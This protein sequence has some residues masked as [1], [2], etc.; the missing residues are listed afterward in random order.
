MWT[1]AEIDRYIRNNL[2]EGRYL[3]TL[4]VVKAS[5]LIAKVHGLSIE[6][7][8]LAAYLHDC[9]KFMREN[10]L[11]EYLN[12]HP[13]GRSDA[14]RPY[15]VLHGF[16]AAVFAETEAGISDPD[17]LEA[18]R[19]HTTG[20]PGM[21]D[22]AKV[23]FLADMVEED[24]DFKGIESL[25]KASLKDLDSAMLIGLDLSLSYLLK[26]GKYIDPDTLHARNYFLELARVG[27]ES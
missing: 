20:T 10:E 14:K 15:E 9:M 4:R 7:A 25:R 21:C 18:I 6:K 19:W 23:V 22:L 5:A 11:R 17:V 1:E 26:S 12:G 16:A 13:S 24:R 3:H 2:K 8:R 27:S